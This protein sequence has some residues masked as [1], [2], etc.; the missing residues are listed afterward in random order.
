M[1]H[2]KVLLQLHSIKLALI[3]VCAI[4]YL[5]LTSTKT[6]DNAPDGTAVAVSPVPSVYQERTSDWLI[7][8]ENPRSRT[9][10]GALTTPTGQPLKFPLQRQQGISSDQTVQKTKV[11]INK[12][13]F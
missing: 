5:A 8:E 11:V 13:E 7:I 12:F 9:D 1:R 2:V 3:S 6:F 4:S 10:L